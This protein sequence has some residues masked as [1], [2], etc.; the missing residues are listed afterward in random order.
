MQKQNKTK[1]I[2]DFIERHKATKTTHQLFYHFEQNDL[3]DSL[4]YAFPLM[5]KGDVMAFETLLSKD[6]R[7]RYG[8]ERPELFDKDIIED[9]LARND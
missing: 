1:E 6:I 7:I 3:I 5:L 4:V 8:I 9:M 2:L